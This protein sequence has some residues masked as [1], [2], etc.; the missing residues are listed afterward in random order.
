[1]NVSLGTL[2]AKNSIRWQTDSPLFRKTWKQMIADPST[3]DLVVEIASSGFIFSLQWEWNGQ[4]K[5]LVVSHLGDSEARSLVLAWWRNK[6]DFY[7]LPEN[8]EEIRMAVSKLIRSHPTQSERSMPIRGYYATPTPEGREEAE[9]LVSERKF[10]PGLGIRLVDSD[11]VD[12]TE[13]VDIFISNKM[14]KRDELGA[15]FSKCIAELAQNNLKVDLFAKKVCE[16]IETEWKKH[17]GDEASD[18]FE[19]I[20]REIWALAKPNKKNWLEAGGIGFA[21]A[22]NLLPISLQAIKLSDII[23]NKKR[24]ADNIE[25]YL[26]KR[27][28]EDLILKDW[29]KLHK[30]LKPTEQESS[31]EP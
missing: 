14:K 11:D 4:A 24:R 21:I 20:R 22:A 3:E 17:F 12:L 25:K 10:N 23:F 29:I 2:E 26:Q 9:K 13:G 7:N 28:V 5:L 16:M 27:I 8:A 19:Q 1:M 30:Y 15:Y 18:G 6:R 31:G